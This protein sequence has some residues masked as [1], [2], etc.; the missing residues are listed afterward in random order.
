MN[1]NSIFFEVDASVIAVEGNNIDVMSG[2][3][4][5]YPDAKINLCGVEIDHELKSIIVGDAVKLHLMYPGPIVYKIS[6]SWSLVRDQGTITFCDGDHAIIDGKERHL[7]F[8]DKF[9]NVKFELNDRIGVTSTRGDY[10]SRGSSLIELRAVEVNVVPPEPMPNQ[11]DVVRS[12]RCSYNLPTFMQ[13]IVERGIDVASRLDLLIPAEDLCAE[14]YSQIMH[15]NVYLEELAMRQV[16]KQYH[17]DKAVFQRTAVK[18]K[19]SSKM[20]IFFET[21]VRWHNG[22]Q[23]PAIAAGIYT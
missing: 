4:E 13:I 21:D 19:N 20:T 23:R 5:D 15:N 3:P 6:P 12:S 14:N 8:V 2:A 16:Y 17:T 11:L 7:C 18:R 22:G 10:Y 9:E 1:R